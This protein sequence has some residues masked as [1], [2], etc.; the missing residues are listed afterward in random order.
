LNKAIQLPQSWP[1]LTIWFIPVF[2]WTSSNSVLILDLL[3]G[4]SFESWTYWSKPHHQF[5]MSRFR[6]QH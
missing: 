3:A 5:A 1:S 4:C 2:V 6:H